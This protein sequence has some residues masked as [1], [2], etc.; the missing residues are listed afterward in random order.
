MQQNMM[1]GLI[2]VGGHKMAQSSLPT[3]YWIKPLKNTS[4]QKDKFLQSSNLVWIKT[5]MNFCNLP[6]KCLR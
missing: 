4:L 1:H 6:N 5:K 2:M 3:H